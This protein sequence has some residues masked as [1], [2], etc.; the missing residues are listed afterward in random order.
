MRGDNQGAHTLNYNS[1]SYG[2]CCEGAYS[3]EHMPQAQYEALVERV[4]YNSKRFNAKVVGHKDLQ[5][6]DCPGAN[7]PLQQLYEIGGNDR[8]EYDISDIQGKLNQLG[9]N[10]DVDGIAGQQTLDAL[11]DFKGSHGL[12]VNDYIDSWT[13]DAI[14]AEI[15]AQQEPNYKQKYVQLVGKIKALAAEL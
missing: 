8:M 1:I 12:Q 6:T 5:A 13:V 15:A 3:R 7:F 14:D 2:I 4:L 10:I 9:Y 11:H